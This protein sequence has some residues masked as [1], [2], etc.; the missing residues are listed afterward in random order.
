MSI[1]DFCFDS[2]RTFHIK[3]F[4]TSQVG[5]FE[6]KEEAEAL[7]EEHVARIQDLQD[8]LSAEKK[9]GLIVV[10]QAMDAAGKDGAIKYVMSGVNPAGIDVYN[11]KKPSEEELEHDYLWRAMRLTPPKGKIAIFNRSY[12]EDVLV[13][14]VHNLQESANLP[15][16]CK[17]KD[18]FEKRYEQINHYEKYLYE[19]GYRIVKI[20]LNISKEE[21]KKQLLQRIDEASKNWKFSDYDMVERDYWNQ[22][23]QAFEDAVNATATK[24]APWYVVPSDKKWFSRYLVAEIIIKALEEMDP[25][26]PT[27]S[28]DRMAKLLEFKNK[29]EE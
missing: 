26:Y 22:Y 23:M 14:K 19:N 7:R 11:F 17:T 2:E 10:L 16:R 6:K 28:E 27:V 8:R 5:K 3:G 9:E 4:D 15:D 24:H 29:L 20:F 25:Q 12:Y 13:V 18:I 21:Q 1:K